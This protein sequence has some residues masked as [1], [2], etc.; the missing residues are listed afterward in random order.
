MKERR[1]IILLYLI[2]WVAVMMCVSCLPSCKSVKVV[3]EY[4]D[5][6]V[7]DTTQVV[8][9]VFQDRYH[10]IYKDGDTIYKVDSVFLYKYKYLNHDVEVYIH[11]SIPYPV[12]VEKII[13][14]RNGYDKFVSAGFWILLA[15]IIIGIIIRVLIKVYMKK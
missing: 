1:F 15:L 4:R 12:E 6:F 8:D 10:T 5:R 2:G 11:D 14:R 7:H 13:R 9:S 3:T